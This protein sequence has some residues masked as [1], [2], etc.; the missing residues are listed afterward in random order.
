MTAAQ[1]ISNSGAWLDT[2]YQTLTGWVI[3]YGHR[4]AGVRTRKEAKKNFPRG[5]TQEQAYTLLLADLALLEAPLRADLADTNT[6]EEE[7]QAYLSLAYDIGLGG[8]AGSATMFEHLLG[9]REPSD[10]TRGQMMLQTCH[11]RGLPDNAPDKFL[12]LSDDGE[13]RWSPLM[14]NRR[15]AERKLYL[16]RKTAGNS[17][18]A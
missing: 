3:G 11:R 4:L 7:L 1:I 16:S 5:V 13:G 8:V 14:F 9:R 17:V 12:Q 10:Q 6:T 18:A 15:W 2:P